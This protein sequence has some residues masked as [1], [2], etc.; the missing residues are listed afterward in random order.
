MSVT[1]RSGLPVTADVTV[2]VTALVALPPSFVAV[3]V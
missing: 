1:T 2:T 3:S